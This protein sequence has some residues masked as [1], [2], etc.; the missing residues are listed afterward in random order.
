M[1]PHIARISALVAFAC[2]AGAF[3][4][5]CV[6]AQPAPVGPDASVWLS[7]PLTL[8]ECIDLALQNNGEIVRA[9]QE[10]EANY[11]ISMQVRSIALPQVKV[12][13]DYVGYDA[14]NV[15]ALELP[16]PAATHRW[17]GSV[18]LIQSIYEGGRIVSSV[19]AASLTKQQALFRYQAVVSDKI[20]E[21]RT[22][23]FDLLLAEALSKSQ[24]A[25]LDLQEKQNEDVSRRLGTGLVAHYDLLRS[26]VALASARP[27]LLRAQNQLRIGKAKFSDLL[28]FRIPSDVWDDIPLRLADPLEA[29]AYDVTLPG[30]ID[31]ALANRPEIQVQEKAVALQHEHLS[32]ARAGFLPSVQVMGGYGGFNDDLDRDIHGWFAG[33]QVNWFLF[34]GL[35][36]QGKIKEAHAHLNAAQSALSDLKR[37]VGLEVR[38]AYSTFTEAKQELEAQEQAQGL[39]EEG[40]RLATSHYHAGEL[41]QLD[42]MQS[43]TTLTDVRS[44]TLQTLRDYDVAVA[45]L[46]RAIG[47]PTDTK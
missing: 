25:A 11:G 6:R 20:L 7:H 19:K 23:Y 30:A 9:K 36:T 16:I 8:K 37:A 28:G 4:P 3:G 45:A 39:A 44:N 41:T 1:K 31:R 14:K 17:S 26:E 10:L 34:D 38:V 18:R 43:Q 47:L 21:V 2:T 33:A 13:G 5:A 35:E 40:L 15:E 42:L 22:A 32:D 46:E 29:E 24:Q 27:K 12:S